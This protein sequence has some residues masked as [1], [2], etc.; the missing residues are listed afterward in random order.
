LAIVGYIL[1]IAGFILVSVSVYPYLPALSGVSIEAGGVKVSIT[2]IPTAVA[3]TLGTG[4]A[5]LLF[6]IVTVAIS[7]KMGTPRSPSHRR[8]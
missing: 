3:V 6:G 1:I 2:D 4:L 5:L 7:M 8:R